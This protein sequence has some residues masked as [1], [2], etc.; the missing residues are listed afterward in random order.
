MKEKRKVI[1]AFNWGQRSGQAKNFLAYYSAN[2]QALTM[3]E[4]LPK[5]GL[6]KNLP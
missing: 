5:K 1:H 3:F 6:D 2:L 4:N